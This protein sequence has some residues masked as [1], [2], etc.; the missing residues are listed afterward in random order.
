MNNGGAWYL[1]ID[2][3]KDMIAGFLMISTAVTNSFASEGKTSFLYKMNNPSFQYF[4]TL[5]LDGGAIYLQTGRVT[6]EECTFQVFIFAI[7]TNMSYRVIK[8]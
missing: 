8:L 3:G 6:L 2:T 7:F 4:L 1:N 5:W